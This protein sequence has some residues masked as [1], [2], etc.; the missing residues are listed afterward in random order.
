MPS[1]TLSDRIAVAANGP[2][3]DPPC[4]SHAVTATAGTTTPRSSPGDLGAVGVGPRGRAAGDGCG[5]Q[6]R[7]PGHAQQAGETGAVADQDPRWGPPR[8]RGEG[9][10]GK[11]AANRTGS[12][13]RNARGTANKARPSATT[14]KPNSRL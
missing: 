12:M 7:R 9:R 13:L 3:T 14:Y 5:G 6:R 1:A 11:S 4:S 8:T 2:H 10:A